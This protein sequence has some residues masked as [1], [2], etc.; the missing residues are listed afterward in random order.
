MVSLF[1]YG[2]EYYLINGFPET[3][4]TIIDFDQYNTTS[5]IVSHPK[6]KINLQLKIGYNPA[7]SLNIFRFSLGT[8]CT[9]AIGN[10]D[11]KCYVASFF[12]VDN[13][14]YM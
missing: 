3:C 12:T 14:G 7:I 11:A 10:Q 1:D 13:I 2:H 8:V 5:V 6:T 4:C 9:N